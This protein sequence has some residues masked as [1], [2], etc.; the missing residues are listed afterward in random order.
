M[1]N[2]SRVRLTNLVI[3]VNIGNV[4]NRFRV[5]SI[6]ISFQRTDIGIL[7]AFF[8]GESIPKMSLF[9][10]IGKTDTLKIKEMIQWEK[11][12]NLVKGENR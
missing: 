7:K 11:E 9:A 2:I 8:G 5:A 10:N 6:T 3:Y 1:V 4:F 12:N